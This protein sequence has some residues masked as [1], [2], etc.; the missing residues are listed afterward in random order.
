[1]GFTTF[2]TYF[3]NSLDDACDILT[4]PDRCI[5]NNKEVLKQHIAYP[6][7][8]AACSTVWR[9][10]QPVLPMRTA[11]TRHAAQW[12]G[13]RRQGLC[14]DNFLDAAA[15]RSSDGD[16]TQQYEREKRDLDRWISG[17]RAPYD[18]TFSAFCAAFT[19]FDALL[20]RLI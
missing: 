9:S 6:I 16:F 4:D 2:T 19:I 5:E 8:K 13:M 20:L 17:L 12:R 3:C 11:Q 15:R 7:C 18:G 10:Q 14:G 1:M